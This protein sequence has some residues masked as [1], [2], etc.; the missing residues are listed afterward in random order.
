MGLTCSFTFIL[1]FLSPWNTQHCSVLTQSHIQNNGNRTPADSTSSD[2]SEPYKIQASSPLW[3]KK[4]MCK[5]SHGC[6]S[7]LA[8]ARFSWHSSLWQATLFFHIYFPVF[9]RQTRN[10]TKLGW[11]LQSEHANRSTGNCNLSVLPYTLPRLLGMRAGQR[12]H[13]CQSK[14]KVWK[15]TI[16]KKQL[17]QALIYTKGHQ[18]FI[19]TPIYHL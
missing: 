3:S 18:Q 7:L 8:I 14:I 5:H 2:C 11:K 4:L 15:E 16:S 19:P 1:S 12:K 6:A 10:C 13:H 9:L 17:F